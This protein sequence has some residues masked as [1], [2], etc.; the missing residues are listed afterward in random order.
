MALRSKA[1][2]TRILSI[3]AQLKPLLVE[4]YVNE[5]IHANGET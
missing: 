5:V 1:T 3:N 4:E 2:S